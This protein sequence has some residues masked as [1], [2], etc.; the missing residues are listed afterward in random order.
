MTTAIDEL[1]TPQH[2]SEIESQ[3]VRKILAS[4]I[5]AGFSMTVYDGGEDTV[6]FSTDPGAV[7][8]ALM[9]TSDDV[10]RLYRAPDADGF[11]QRVGWV[12]LIWG[13]DCDVISDYSDNEATAAL[14]ADAEAH[15]E[16]FN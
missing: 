1:P 3:I 9:T 8:A 16:K 10:I 14:L 15:A 6:S 7:L 12:R 4:A 13:N 2:M 11:R 5:A